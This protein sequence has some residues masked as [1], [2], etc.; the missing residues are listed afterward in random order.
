MFSL[1]SDGIFR[2]IT[3][4]PVLSRKSFVSALSSPLQGS[5]YP[6]PP[7]AVRNCKN[8]RNCSMRWNS[9]NLSSSNVDRVE[10]HVVSLY[11]SVTNISKSLKFTPIN[12]HSVDFSTSFFRVVSHNIPRKRKSSKSLISYFF[13][14]SVNDHDIADKFIV[15]RDIINVLTKPGSCYISSAFFLSALCWEF[16]LITILF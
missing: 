5:F 7:I 4:P 3:R 16:L 13:V 11:N 1:K 14:N 15:G 12:S 2:S 9:A 8:I 6:V 10:Y